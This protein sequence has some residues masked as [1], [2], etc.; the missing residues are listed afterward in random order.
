MLTGSVLGITETT[1][2]DWNFFMI[3]GAPGVI[4]VEAESHFTSLADL[5]NQAGES[6]QTLK[7]S[8]SLTGGIWHTKL[9]ALEEAAGVEFQFIPFNKGQSAQPNRGA[10]GRG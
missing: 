4:S 7:V 6:P 5:I 2:K 10:F 9:L 8:A 3:A 1:A